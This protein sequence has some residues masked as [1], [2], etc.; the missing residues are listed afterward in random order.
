M[1]ILLTCLLLTVVCSALPAVDN[2][3]KKP[4]DNN[5]LAERVCK[6]QCWMLKNSCGKMLG[7]GDDQFYVSKHCPATCASG[8]EKWVKPK[9]CGKYDCPKYHSKQKNGY[10]IR[11]YVPTTWV[12]TFKES[13]TRGLFMKLFR[14]IR[15]ANSEAKK[16]P[17]TVPVL[18]ST[19]DE[20]KTDSSKTS[21]MFYVHLAPNTTAPTPTAKDVYLL[22]SPKSCMYVR[23]FGGWAWSIIVEHQLEKLDAALKQD[24]LSY[25]PNV[26]TVASYNSPWEFF[27][28]HNEVFRLVPADKT[29]EMW[30]MV[31]Q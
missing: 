25:Q 2:V 31:I 16:I 29:E 10:E 7:C 22:P 21:M 4:V 24:N 9:F 15:G 26:R 12:Y 14:Y 6:G 8:E 19:V 18:T 27:W 5:K 20:Q 30:N 17:M 11:C 23:S 13:G 3:T 28:R 1:R